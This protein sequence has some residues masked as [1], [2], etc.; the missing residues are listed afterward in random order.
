MSLERNYQ[1]PLVVEALCE[2]YFRD[3]TWDHTIPGIYYEKVKKEFP[4]KQQREVQQAQITPERGT[5]SA[6]AQMQPSWIQ[7]VSEQGDRMRRIAENLLLV[8]QLRPYHHFAEWELVV[9]NALKLYQEIAIPQKIE[10]CGVRYINRVEIPGTQVTMEDYFK[11]YPQLPESPGNTHA[12]FLLRV[13]IPRTEQAHVVL[14]TFGTS[15]PR[16][17]HETTRHYS[18]HP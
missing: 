14:I 7:F 2:I 1:K 13:E 11:I 4:K 16:Q 3:S 5:A 15:T 18:S 12:P 8:N 9:C 17:F 10:R 6:N